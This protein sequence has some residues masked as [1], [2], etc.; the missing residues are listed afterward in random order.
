[1]VLRSA[2]CASNPRLNNSPMTKYSPALPVGI[3]DFR[4]LLSRG[5]AIG[6]MSRPFSARC[7]VRHAGFTPAA[8]IHEPVATISDTAAVHVD[9]DQ[10]A[11]ANLTLSFPIR[12][13]PRS[14]AACPDQVNPAKRW[15]TLSLVWLSC[16]LSCTN[17]LSQLRC[18]R[19]LLALRLASQ[20]SR[21]NSGLLRRTNGRQFLAEGPI[22]V[23]A[24][25]R[26]F[27]SQRTR[28]CP[29]DGTPM[30]IYKYCRV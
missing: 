24:P 17:S 20:P 13:T 22:A 28:E 18:Y 14:A 16:L 29:G 3:P 11:R 7:F 10:G 15:R 5:C 27:R 25:Q 9:L 26:S 1:M 6:D 23:L 2:S 19:R 12:Q 21:R 4:F 8:Y 30:P